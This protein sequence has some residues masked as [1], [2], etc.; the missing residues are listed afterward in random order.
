MWSRILIFFMFKI[1][2]LSLEIRTR[3]YKEYDGYC[4][5]SEKELINTDSSIACAVACTGRNNGT[6]F[7]YT[8]T[9]SK[10]NCE[11]VTEIEYDDLVNDQFQIAGK[12]Y[13]FNSYGT[14]SYLMRR[15]MSILTPPVQTSTASISE[16]LAITSE[17][18]GEETSNRS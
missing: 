13:L 12:K 15:S 7:G 3:T 9:H 2:S 4:F 17:I 14:L 10:D 5:A 8:Y 1:V 6:C 11:L 16:C 18:L